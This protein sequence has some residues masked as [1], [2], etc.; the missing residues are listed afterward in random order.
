MQLKINA[1]GFPNVFRV[2]AALC[3]LNI[4]TLVP[5]HSIATHDA[6]CKAEKKRSSMLCYSSKVR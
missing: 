4:L 5:L 6:S 2:P 1:N 3:R